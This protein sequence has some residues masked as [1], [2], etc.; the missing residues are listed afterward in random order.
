MEKNRVRIIC[1]PYEKS[2]KYMRWCLEEEQDTYT[3][4]DLGSKSQLL[5]DEK[6]TNATIQH[7][8]HEI[9]EE[10]AS[11]YNRGKVGLEI[12]FD[13]TKEDYEDLKEVVD[14][15]FNQAG[16]SCEIGDLYIDSASAVMPEIQK[17]FVNL[18]QVFKE[19]STEE[20]NQ[21]IAKFLDATKTEIPICVV[22]C[23]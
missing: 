16:V 3:W 15:F 14:K 21:I 7:N 12:V 9:V 2:I 6:Y 8:A 11:E 5:S 10:I 4:K 17:V 18:A 20:I 23:K 19:Y 13:G 1:N 22:A